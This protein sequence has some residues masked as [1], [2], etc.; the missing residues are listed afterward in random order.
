MF[1]GFL[2]IPFNLSMYLFLI[3]MWGV[4]FVWSVFGL[5]RHGSLIILWGALF[6]YPDSFFC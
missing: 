6:I 2:R 3:F 1:G 5:F 4:F